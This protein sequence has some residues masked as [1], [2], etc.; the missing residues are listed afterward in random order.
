MDKAL[1]CHAGG[2]G[3]NL[4]RTKVYSAPTLLGTLPCA[5]SLAIPVRVMCEV[6]GERRKGVKKTFKQLCYS[7]KSTSAYRKNVAFIRLLEVTQKSFES[8][9]FF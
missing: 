3:S 5:L 8:A 9:D 7:A 4:D 1:A 6:K 2:Q